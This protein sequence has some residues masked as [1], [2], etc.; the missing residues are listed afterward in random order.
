MLSRAFEAQ[1]NLL[2]IYGVAAGGGALSLRRSLNITRP[3]GPLG[4][5]PIGE[6]D[7]IPANALSGQKRGVSLQNEAAE[8]LANAG[9][10]VEQ[11]PIKQGSGTTNPDLKVEGRV[12][13]VYSPIASTSARSMV[14]NMS[15]K[16]G[17]T[18]TER[19]VLY[20]KENEVSRSDLRA[21]FNSMNTGIKE[22]IVI[23]KDGTFYR[24]P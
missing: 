1:R 14:S 18:Q 19:I 22:V 12:F 13:D 2:E 3:A 24:L 21:A 17:S 6:P 8:V 16:V 15:D 9:Y 7:G 23:G 20:L 4:G 5:K 10:R 11:L